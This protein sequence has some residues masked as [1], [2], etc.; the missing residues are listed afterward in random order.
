MTVRWTGTPSGTLSSACD[1]EITGSRVTDSRSESRTPVLTACRSFVE[2]VPNRQ[3]PTRCSGPPRAGLTPSIVCSR[4]RPPSSA[5]AGRNV[6][7]SHRQIRDLDCLQARS[8]QLRV[9]PSSPSQTAPIRS[10]S[11][12]TI[13]C[14]RASS[15]ESGYVLFSPSSC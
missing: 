9:D 3:R 11:H 6:E 12:G 2:V 5:S 4:V 7:K 10:Y 15:T 14:T 8:P 13:S 1:T